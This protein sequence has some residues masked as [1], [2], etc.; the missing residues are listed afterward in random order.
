MSNGQTSSSLF[1]YCML[2][3]AHGYLGK[4]C[5]VIRCPQVGTTSLYSAFYEI[6]TI[7]RD[8]AG[9]F[10]MQYKILQYLCQV[11]I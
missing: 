7:F 4:I 9:Q 8:I 1:V 2:K 11:G 3:S 6:L 5:H 10:F